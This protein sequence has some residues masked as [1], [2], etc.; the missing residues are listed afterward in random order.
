MFHALEK[1]KN[2]MILMTTDI[3]YE[4]IKSVNELK[5]EIVN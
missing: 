5:R 1:L 3:K 2:N 4:I